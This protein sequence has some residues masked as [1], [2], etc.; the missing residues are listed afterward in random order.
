MKSYVSK[1]IK[2][3]K[4]TYYIDV[5]AFFCYT[6]LLQPFLLYQNKGDKS[7][8]FDHLLR[9]LNQVEFLRDLKAYQIVE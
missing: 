4:K 6:Y 7:V 9:I 5:L 8:R 1:Q 3:T 2:A